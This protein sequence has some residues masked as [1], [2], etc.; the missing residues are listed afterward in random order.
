M[1]FTSAS[2]RAFDFFEIGEGER[3]RDR[4]REDEGERE[5]ERDGDFLTGERERDAEREDAAREST[6]AERARPLRCG[7]T[8]RDRDLDDS[9]EQDAEATGSTCFFAAGLAFTLSLELVVFLTVTFLSTG[10]ASFL[11]GCF[12]SFSADFFFDMLFYECRC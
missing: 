8:D 7:E 12:F 5:T 2:V 11:G 3:E 1:G 6:E 4:D 10:L 9:S